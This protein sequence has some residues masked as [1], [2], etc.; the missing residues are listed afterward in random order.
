MIVQFKKTGK[1][2]VAIVP[3][4]DYEALAAKAQ[5]ADEDF[6]TAR[7]VA[8]A[9]KEISAGMPLIPKEFVDRIASGEN[10]LRVLREWRG[11]TQIYVSRKADIG[12]FGPGS[13]RADG[14]GQSEVTSSRPN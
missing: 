7:L 8:R 4:R 14:P 1:G 2:E 3:R 11:E 12:V 10:A 5:E 9:R 6:G 13:N